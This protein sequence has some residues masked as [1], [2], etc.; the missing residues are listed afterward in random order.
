MMKEEIITWLDNL[1]KETGLPPKEVIAFNLGLFEGES[2]YMMYL[3]GAYEYTEDS[4]DWASLKMPASPIMYY[5]LP[6]NM[7]EEDWESVLDNCV[8]ELKELESAGKLNIP[9]FEN[10]IAITTGFDDGDLV[11]IR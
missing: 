1:Q 9:L 5:K 7:N 8:R 10:A 2:G 11:R 6:D 4:D 3:V